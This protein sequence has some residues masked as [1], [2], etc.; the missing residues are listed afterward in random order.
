MLLYRWSAI[1]C[2][3][4]I[5]NTMKESIVSILAIFLMS[6]MSFHIRI[7]A[8]NVATN[9]NILCNVIVLYV[10]ALIDLEIVWQDNSVCESVSFLYKLCSEWCSLFVRAI[11]KRFALSA[12]PTLKIYPTRTTLSHHHNACTSSP[13]PSKISTSHHLP[14]RERERS[15][16]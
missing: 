14:Q 12:V 9:G 1:G 7:C 8:R 15:V 2:Y 11:S 5:G 16:L 4:V 6:K 13:I 3:D 10:C